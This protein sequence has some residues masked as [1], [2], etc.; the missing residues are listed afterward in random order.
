MTAPTW[1]TFAAQLYGAYFV[2]IALIVF[3]VFGWFMWSAERRRRRIA[4]QQ[5]THPH[6]STRML[7]PSRDV[8]DQ[9][10]PNRYT[11]PAQRRT[12]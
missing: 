7:R 9:D 12:R 5:A 10:Q 8:F 11:V 4:R 2:A 6:P 3:A 1:L